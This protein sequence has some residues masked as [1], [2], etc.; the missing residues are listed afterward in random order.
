M[1]A[2]IIV[3]VWPAAAK[4]QRRWVR[5]SL[6]L[7]NTGIQWLQYILPA[8]RMSGGDAGR[9]TAKLKSED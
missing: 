8:R 1:P 4:L 5:M 6:W 2:E 9:V 7:K 3:C